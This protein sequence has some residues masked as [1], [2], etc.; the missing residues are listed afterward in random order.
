LC[1]IDAL[2]QLT[3]HTENRI[4]KDTKESGAVSNLTSIIRNT[5]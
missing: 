1:F 5:N 3:T 2:V 4:R